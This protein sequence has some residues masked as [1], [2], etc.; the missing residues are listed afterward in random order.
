M[1]LHQPMATVTPTLDGPVLTVLARHGVTFT[2]GQLHRILS[3]YSEEGIRKVLKRL[4]QQ[5]VVLADR[6]GN[7][8]AYRLNDEHLAAAAILELAA[9]PSTLLSRLE[10][11]LDGWAVRPVYAAV[12][13]SAARGGMRTSSDIDLLLIR[14]AATADEVWEEQTEALAAAVQR[15]TGNELRVLEFHV[16]DMPS[17]QHEPVLREVARDGL[18]V[19]GTAAWIRRQLPSRV[20]G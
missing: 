5:G 17:V 14:P 12:F 18:T 8:Y 11:A 13:G 7:A 16:L 1:Q 6:V 9:M 20:A 10:E 19:H 3:A 4:V 15:W 2:T